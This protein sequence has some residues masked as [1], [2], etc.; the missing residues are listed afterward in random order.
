MPKW[1]FWG[2]FGGF[3]PKNAVLAHFESRK[4]RKKQNIQK[5]MLIF[6]A[7]TLR[8]IYTSFW[9]IWTISLGFEAF[10]V[11][12]KFPIICRVSK[13]MRVFWQKIREFYAKIL[14]F[15]KINENYLIHFQFK[16]WVIWT[17]SDQKIA[18]FVDFLVIFSPIDF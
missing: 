18:I 17:I 12:K 15:L 2:K 14:N 16:F 9:A 7:K 6:V 4:I 5:P 8:Y 11:E 3:Y 1:L 10:Y 13:K